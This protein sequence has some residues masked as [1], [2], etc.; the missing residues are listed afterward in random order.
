MFQYTA[1]TH[2]MNG[3][4]KRDELR[5]RKDKSLIAEDKDFHAEI[6]GN[7]KKNIG[8]CEKREPQY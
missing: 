8:W 5:K 6:D 3:D 1:S 2:S 7:K 4:I